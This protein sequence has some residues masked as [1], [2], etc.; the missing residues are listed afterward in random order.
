MKSLK[1]ICSTA[2][3]CFYFTGN[4]RC[5]RD[6][7]F[8]SPDVTSECTGEIVQLLVIWSTFLFQVSS[9]SALFLSSY[10]RLTTRSLLE[11]SRPRLPHF[12]CDSYFISLF[13]YSQLLFIVLLS[14]PCSIT[15]A[16]MAPPTTQI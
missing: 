6:H 10:L 7:S 8:G 15:S 4:E 11:V 13:F 3:E 2:S 12:Y 9:S 5:V 1:E 16:P 14:S